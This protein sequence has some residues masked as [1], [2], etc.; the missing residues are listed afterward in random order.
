MSWRAITE[1]DLLLSIS[2]AEL[3]AL[4]AAVLASGQDDPVANSI[5]RTVDEVR[6][7]IAACDRNEL[8]EGD[9][10]PEKLI[11]PAVDVII[12][13]I[14][15]RAGGT[16]IDESGYRRDR[17]KDARRLFERVAD[18]KYAIEAPAV[19][20][21]EKIGGPTPSFTGRAKHFS[22]TDQDGI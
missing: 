12:L 6:G 20:D 16:M 1:D 19:V 14:M 5:I 10:M 2:G 7:Y 21:S 3:E 22:R 13:D 15:G 17:A 18:C 9:T 8:G 11:R 4:R